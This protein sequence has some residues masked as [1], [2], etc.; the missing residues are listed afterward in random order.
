MTEP[1]KTCLRCGEKAD[2]IVQERDNYDGFCYCHC[3][4]CGFI[5]SVGE[6]GYEIAY[7]REN[8]DVSMRQWAEVPE[9]V[10]LVL[11]SS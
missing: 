6:T 2:T 8:R 3:Q 11:E 1:Y 4:S 9:G 7:K 5:W 10:L